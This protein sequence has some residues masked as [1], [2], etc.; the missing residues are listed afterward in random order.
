[1]IDFPDDDP[2]EDA[3]PLGDGTADTEA[4]VQCPWCGAPCVIAL[5]PGGGADQEYVED[6][7]VCCRP[8]IVRVRYGGSGAATVDLEE[9]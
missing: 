4:E 1:M 2:L 9:G 6:C 8:S 3:F 5:D 7:E